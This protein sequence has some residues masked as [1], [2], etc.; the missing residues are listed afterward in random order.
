MLGVGFDHTV[1]LNNCMTWRSALFKFFVFIA[2][3]PLL[4]KG[5][6]DLWIHQDHLNTDY[7]NTRQ[8]ASKLESAI[9]T[10]ETYH[11]AIIAMERKMAIIL[12]KTQLRFC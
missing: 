4:S 11:G 3:S 7:L 9:N 6:K 8:M 5:L 10:M 1:P 12:P 2:L